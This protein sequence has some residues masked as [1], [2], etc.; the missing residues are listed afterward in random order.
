MIPIIEN[1]YVQNTYSHIYEHFSNTRHYVW[2]CVKSFL[3]SKNSNELGLEIG[4]GNGK[5]LL[6]NKQLT[7]IGVDL[8]QELLNLIPNTINTLRSDCCTLP[9]KEN[10]FDYSLSIACFHHLSNNIR[11]NTA[12]IEMIRVLKSKGN[13]CI[14]VWS[15][16]N[17]DKYK[18]TPGDNFVSWNKKY[19]R[20]YY[21]YNKSM[22]YQY[23]ENVKDL[24]NVENIY[25]EKGN[26]IIIFNKL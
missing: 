12:L 26:W 10:T 18:F 1:K 4:C 17:Q 24:I 21:V 2:P 25:N 22:I 13:G 20:Y 14:T 8:S 9:F 7:I 11:R 15:V 3:N 5:N 23:L 6:Y 19:Q 16:E